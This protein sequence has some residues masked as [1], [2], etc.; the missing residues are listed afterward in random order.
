M[1]RMLSREIMDRVDCGLF[2]PIPG[3]NGY[4]GEPDDSVPNFSGIYHCLSLA[5]ADTLFPEG[6]P[7]DVEVHWVRDD[8]ARI[9]FVSDKPKLLGDAYAFVLGA[10]PEHLPEGFEWP[11]F[12]HETEDRYYEAAE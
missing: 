7:D 3:E 8:E 4:S 1:K 10:W 11:C 12:S 6:L 5:D 9:V 2:F